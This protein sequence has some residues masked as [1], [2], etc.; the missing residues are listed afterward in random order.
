MITASALVGTSV[1]PQVAVSFQLPETD[2]V[3]ARA[4]EVP[5]SPANRKIAVPLR[6]DSM[7]CFMVDFWV[8]VVVV[9][10]LLSDADLRCAGGFFVR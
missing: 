3:L 5:S 4:A 8:L 6:N 1:P 10:A 9:I 7:D 2:A